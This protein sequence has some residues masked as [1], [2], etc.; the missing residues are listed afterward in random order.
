ME[1]IKI[2]DR[3][4]ELI[5]K[6]VVIWE[7]AVRETHLFLS[8]N[9]VENIKTYVPMALKNI[10]TLLVAKIE[11]EVGFIG[12]ENSKIEMLF[13]APK[14][15]G[16]GIGRSLIEY[17]IKNY[18]IKQVGVNEQN[19]KAVGFYE[20]LGFKTYR[21]DEKDGQGNSYPILHMKL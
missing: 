19:P 4:E 7:D 14:N 12:V 18:N 10:E 15:H 20:H 9:E 13:V 16:Q 21:R 1:I 6:L 5:K 17:V 2:K 3:S 11:D 8:N